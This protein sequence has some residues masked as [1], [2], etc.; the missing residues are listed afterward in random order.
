MFFLLFGYVHLRS[1]KKYIIYE[2]AIFFWFSFARLSFLFKK[3]ISDNKM[4]VNCD[5]SSVTIKSLLITK[6]FVFFVLFLSIQKKL[7]R[8]DIF[9]Q[10][11]SVYNVFNRI[12]LKY[13]INEIKIIQKNVYAHYQIPFMNDPVTAL[14]A[15]PKMK[16]LSKAK[17]STFVLKS[18][19][20]LN[21]IFINSKNDSILYFK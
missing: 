1:G 15:S 5:Y 7:I 19:L 11:C 20:N 6:C 14:K 8:F 4:I 12:Y 16:K 21:S 2:I 3:G 9:I 17:N 13:P 10:A 18:N